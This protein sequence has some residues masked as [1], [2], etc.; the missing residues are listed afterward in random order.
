MAMHFILRNITSNQAEYFLTNNFSSPTHWPDW[1]RLVEKYYNT[2]FYYLGY[3]ERE[4]LIGIYPFH[5]V[6]FKRFLS[7]RL[8]GQFHFIPNGG[9][10]FSKPV[11][12]KEELFKNNSVTHNQTF[13]LPFLGEFKADY[14]DLSAISKATLVINLYKSED[15]IWKESISGKRRNMI[16]KAEKENVVI[17]KLN[18]EDGLKRFYALYTEASKRFTNQQLCYEFIHEM[19]YKSTNINL[20]I[21]MAY[22]EGRQ[23]SNVGVISDK[24]Y[25]I[26]WLGNNAPE[27]VN[28]GQSELLQWYAIKSMKAKGC[29][30]YDLCYIEPEYLPAIYK[31]KSG[32][33][34][35]REEIKLISY[36]PLLFRIINNIL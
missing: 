29:K 24:N 27:A 23:L 25:S 36:K 28:I 19:F 3:F 31:Y 21:W 7:K 9:W 1:N 8:S 33:S 34:K 11:Q 20:D 10:I 6:V 16:R 5:E 15:E 26:Y 2:R 17:E 32:F 13:T 30:Y 22:K 12:V 35:D 18:S 14:S 4:E